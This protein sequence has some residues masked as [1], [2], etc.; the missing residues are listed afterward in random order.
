VLKGA[1]RTLSE[2]RVD[3]ILA[4]CDFFPRPGEPHGDFAEILELVSTH[5][6]RVVSFYTG[7]VDD[8]GW[9]WGDVLFVEASRSRGGRVAGSPIRYR[10]AGGPAKP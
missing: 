3:F 7:G 6:Y 9:V 1:Q 2:R 10:V 4:E 8:L 5:G